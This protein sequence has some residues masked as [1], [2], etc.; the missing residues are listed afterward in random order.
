MKFCENCGT[1]LEDSAVFCEECGIKQE[2]IAEDQLASISVE[3]EQGTQPIKLSQACKP[4]KKEISG[5]LMTALLFLCSPLVFFEILPFFPCFLFGLLWF[6]I[7]IGI[8]VLMW[9]KRSWK[10]WLK[11]AWTIA[12]IIMFL[13]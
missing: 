12:Y 7:T 11:V 4:A 10:T 5:W 8:L 9:M 3:V 2:V 13:I 6:V 1:Q